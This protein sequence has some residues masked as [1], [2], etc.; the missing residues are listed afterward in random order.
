M[1]LAKDRE[2][3]RYLGPS[4][5]FKYL[6][7]TTLQFKKCESCIFKHEVG[8]RMDLFSEKTIEAPRKEL[9]L[10]HLQN[11]FQ[12]RRNVTWVDG[13]KLALERSGGVIPRNQSS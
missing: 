10:P 5:L 8:T 7:V 3:L 11:V 12:K 1:Y 2:S 4:L 9:C 13:K 6:R